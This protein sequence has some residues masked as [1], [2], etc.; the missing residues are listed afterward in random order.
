MFVSMNEELLKEIVLTLR[1]ILKWTRFSGMQQLR[2]VLL[3]I[4]KTDTE[5]AIYE[6]TDG[7]RSTREI[8]TLVGVK[9]HATIAAY[10]KKWS[11]TGIV[12]P[13]QRIPGRYQHIC[14]LEE[15]GIEV[16]KTILERGGSDENR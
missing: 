3:N 7:K 9:S 4:L 16:P 5:K 2:N 1:E 13:T 10:W 15:V 12:Q 14:S 11:K 6:L 8:A